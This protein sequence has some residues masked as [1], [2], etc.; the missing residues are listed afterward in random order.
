MSNGLPINQMKIKALAPWFGAKRTLAPR[1]AELLGSH[2]AYWEPFCGSMAVLLAKPPCTCESVNDLHGDL[3]NLARTIQDPKAGPRLYR[4]LRRVLMHEDIVR[5]ARSVIRATQC[6]PG[7]ERAFWFFIDA[8]LGR[9]GVGGTYSRNNGFC[10]RFTDRGGSPAVRF[11]SAVNSIPVWRRRM[12]RVAI[13]SCDAFEILDRIDD[14]PRVAVY[15]D[16]PYLVKGAKYEHDFLPIDHV[17]LAQALHRFK[18]ARIVLSYYDHPALQDLY[19]DW[20]MDRIQI[21]KAM[22][23][24]G[25]RGK[26]AT[27]AVEVLLVNQAGV[28]SGQQARADGDRMSLFSVPSVPSVAHSCNLRKSAQSAEETSIGKD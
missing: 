19:P 21:S 1:I 7:E 9:N 3:I 11:S 24:Q 4:R 16:P 6:Q 22:A 14:S 8:W 13:L 28:K 23:H 18:R 10:R 2:T 12:S 26:N 15:V 20:A 25:Y 5:E 17:R 27:K